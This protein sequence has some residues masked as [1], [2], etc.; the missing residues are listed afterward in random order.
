MFFWDI[1]RKK[2]L[3]YGN[4]QISRSA[5]QIPKKKQWLFFVESLINESNSENISENSF[6]SW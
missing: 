1:N 4:T 2:K 6:I 5:S 3:P